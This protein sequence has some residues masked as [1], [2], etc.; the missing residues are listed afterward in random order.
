MIIKLD[1]FNI[2]SFNNRRAVRKNHTKPVT[3]W[4][5]HR[6]LPRNFQHLISKLTFGSALLQQ[7]CVHFET[8]V[9]FS[10][11]YDCLQF[12][13]LGFS[14]ASQTVIQAGFLGTGRRTNG[15]RREKRIK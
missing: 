10:T 9:G 8:A 5:K 7:L 11:R 12:P 15:R 3:R 6:I 1:E 4:R 2:V 14:Q 13:T